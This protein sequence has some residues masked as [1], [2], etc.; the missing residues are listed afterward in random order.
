MKFRFPRFTRPFPPPTSE[1]QVDSPDEK[2]A[3]VEPS[4][5]VFDRHLEAWKDAIRSD[6]P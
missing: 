5:R 4:E 3:P 6:A 1:Q 2:T